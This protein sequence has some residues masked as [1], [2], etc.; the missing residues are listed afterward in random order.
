MHLLTLLI[1]LISFASAGD[2]SNTMLNFYCELGL[3]NDSSCSIDGGWTSWTP[4]GPCSGKCGLIG[5]RIRHRTC[6]N[7]LPSSNGAPCIGP[8]YQVESCQI[9]GCTMNDYESNVYNHPIR[10]EELKI[11]ILGNNAMHYWNAMNCVKHNVGCPVSGGWSTW[12]PWSSCTALCGR[13]QKYRTRI[14]N[15]PAPSSSKLSCNDSA[16]ET[17]SCIGGNCKKHSKGTWS[18][19]SEW[20]TCSTECGNGIQTRKRSCLETQNTQDSSCKGVTKDIRGCTINNCSI[21]GIWSSWTVWSPCSTSCGIGTQLRNRMCTNPS[22]SGDGLSCFGSASEI[23]QCFTRPCVVKTHEVAHFTEK[24]S[25]LYT[26][27]EKP[28]RLLHMYLRFLPLAPFGVLIYRFENDCKGS[29]CD[30]VKLSLQNGKITLLSQVSGCILGLVHEDKLEIGQWHILSVT[31]CGTHAVLRVNDGPHKIATFSCTP[32]SYNLDH[33]MKVGEG[34]QGQI[35]Q[36]AIN[37]VSFQLHVLK[38]KYNKKHVNA[39]ISSNN[40][41]YFMGD[42]EEGF[43]HIDITESI[44][45]PCPKNMQSWQIIISIKTEDINGIIAVIPDYFSNKYIL[46]QMEQGRIKLKFHQ[47]AAH[48]ATESTEHILIGEW[49]EVVLAQNGKNLYM[50]VNGNDK[51]HVAL[52]SEKMVTS[53][54]NIFIGAIHDEMRKKICPKCEELSQMSFTLGYLS[55]DGNQIDLLSLPVL[56]TTN[57]RFSS[58]TISLSDYYEE[59][60]LLLG[61]ELKLSCFYDKSLHEKKV[62]SFYKKTYVTWLLM[63]KLLQSYGIINDFFNL[64]DDGRVSTISIASYTTREAIENFYSCHI[65]HYS[66]NSFKDSNRILLSFGVTVIDR[67]KEVENIYWKEW[68]FICGAIIS[69]FIFL[70]FWCLFEILQQLQNGHS[71]FKLPPLNDFNSTYIINFILSKDGI[72]LLGSQQ[73]ADEIVAKITEHN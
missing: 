56:E 65:H 44:A 64:K 17:K 48:I 72:T 28:S 43:I 61:Q 41:Q 51:K 29:M 71:L 46:L 16:F 58:R 30:F 18:K 13:G 3:R 66:N 7:P 2:V 50:Q 12:G 52:M 53:A 73:A 8:S 67:N 1:L 24:S 21:N 20:N 11:K 45:A 6:N 62:H 34:F 36:I 57:K 69:C 5:K 33:T 9:V 70:I 54:S 68:R 55:I 10:K 32:V 35:Q 63:D 38:G 27:S 49:F 40:V 14:C 15:S 39:P 25:L 19:W 26:T 47:E 37:F 42:D 4:W 22:P 23:R 31:I 60:S 59:V